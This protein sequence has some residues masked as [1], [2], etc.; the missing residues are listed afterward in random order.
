MCVGDV[1][2]ITGLF[3]HRN[4]S[5]II[6]FSYGANNDKGQ[7]KELAAFNYNTYNQSSINARVQDSPFHQHSSPRLKPHL[8]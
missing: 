7:L 6:E 3:K 1:G 2:S 5:F 4:V 8:S